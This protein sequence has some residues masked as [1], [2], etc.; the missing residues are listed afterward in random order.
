M[1]TH[2]AAAAREKTGPTLL[3]QADWDLTCSAVW[4]AR[5]VTTVYM[6]GILFGASVWSTVSD[7][8]GRRRTYL[9]T[10]TLFTVMALASA[11][12]PNFDTLIALRFFT[13]FFDGGNALV[14]FCLMSEFIG[15]K[16]R[17]VASI[18]N[19]CVFALAEMLLALIAFYVR[20]WR[21]LLLTLALVG[22][23][24]M[25]L[26]YPLLLPSPRWLLTKGYPA[27]ARTVLAT[28]AERNHRPM[29]EGDLSAPAR[30]QD[31]TLYNLMRSNIP[32]RAYALI[33]MFS[34]FSA[35]YGAGSAARRA[36]R[37]C[38]PLLTHAHPAA[39]FTTASP[40]LAGL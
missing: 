40:S 26:T 39:L 34:W 10:C 2:H 22:G 17:A 33:M 12:A 4:R 1:R 24:P 32:T 38:T 25:L 8:V 35:R 3:E 18:S 5:F 14:A 30:G 9:V 37:V 6:L 21:S 29:I 28:M 27:H 20:P 36:V 16:W 11:F 31:V 7:R 15:P 13:A 23:L 19:M